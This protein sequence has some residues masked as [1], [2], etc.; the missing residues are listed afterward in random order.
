MKKFLNLKNIIIIL[1]LFIFYT[2]ICAFSYANTISDNI[3]NNVFRL[4]VIA[5]SDS[6]EDQ[7]LKLL[8]KDNLI[9]YMNTICK[10][11]KTKDE[12]IIIAKQNKSIFYKIAKETIISNGYNYDVKINFGNYIFPTKNYGDISLPSGNY[13]ALKVE[14]GEAQGKNWWCVM[15]PPLCFIDIS[16]GIVPDESK[17]NLKENLSN[18]EFAIINNQNDLTINFKFKILELFNLSN[19]LTAKK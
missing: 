2:F 12:A 16:S 11:C 14:I 1:F 17:E 10:N 9:K 15:F 5:N 18:E 7:N 19:L 3:S 4:H 6:S 8:V 13:D